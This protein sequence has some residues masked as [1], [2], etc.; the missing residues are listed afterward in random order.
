[1]RRL[2]FLWAL[3]AGFIAATPFHV[4]AQQPMPT[5]GVV[6]PASSATSRFPGFFL[7]SLK[8]FGWEDGRNCRVIF[9]WAEARIDRMPA[10]N[11][12]VVFSEPGILAAQRAT[13]TI[14]IVVTASDM[15]RNELAA[16]MAKPGGNVTGINLVAEE[17]NIKR[18]EIL[19][20]A[21]AG[22]RR[23]GTLV[24][25]CLPQP[26]LETAAHQL[27]LDLIQVNARNP[28]EVTRRLDILESSHV[29]PS[30]CWTVR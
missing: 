29:T 10:L 11:V 3:A 28:E 24:A 4:C 19:H 18:L 15:V 27:D 6:F 12:L 26:K 21:V 13:T 20:E 14:P 2:H 5:V 7:P 22:A 30:T 1:V 25:P 8:E 9:R 16:S 23:I 17:L